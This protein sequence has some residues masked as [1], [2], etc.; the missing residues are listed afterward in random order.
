[1]PNSSQKTILSA[2]KPHSSSRIERKIRLRPREVIET[3]KLTLPKGGKRGRQVGG[4]IY[5][6]LSSS[7]ND[8]S[9]G[10]LGNSNRAAAGRTRRASFRCLLVKPARRVAHVRSALTPPCKWPDISI[11]FGMHAAISKRLRLGKAPIFVC[12]LFCVIRGLREE[13]IYRVTQG[14]KKACE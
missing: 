3:S 6:G 1:M 10:H 14:V 11:T 9:R 4:G 5:R 8:N 2:C 13:V 12:C 7:R